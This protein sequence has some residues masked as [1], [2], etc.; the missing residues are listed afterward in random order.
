[1]FKDYN[2]VLQYYRIICL[3]MSSLGQITVLIDFFCFSLQRVFLG[4][5]YIDIG[6]K[7]IVKQ[8]TREL[9]YETESTTPISDMPKIGDDICIKLKEKGSH[10]YNVEARFYM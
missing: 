8:K 2:S 10:L 6:E 3:F 9:K 1:M 5:L 7:V 4:R